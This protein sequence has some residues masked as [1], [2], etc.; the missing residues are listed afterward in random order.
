MYISMMPICMYI[1][2]HR[3][4]SVRRRRGNQ[5]RTFDLLQPEA[6][7]IQRSDMDLLLHI[8][9]FAFLLGIFASLHFWNCPSTW[10]YLYLSVECV[11]AARSAAEDLSIYYY[12]WLWMGLSRVHEL[13][14]SGG[15]DALVAVRKSAGKQK[16]LTKPWKPRL[17]GCK[18][19]PTW[20]KTVCFA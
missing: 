12:Y 13:D 11:K 2:E 16:L 19:S 17:V 10:F 9:L 14:F 8:Y 20:A 7:R 1:L 4:L 3:Q 15:D 5:I 18:S 6:A